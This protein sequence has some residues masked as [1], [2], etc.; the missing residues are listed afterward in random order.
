MKSAITRRDFL[1]RAALAGAS[2]ALPAHA[3]PARNAMFVSLN[4]ALTA[5]KNVGW[6]E[7]ARLAARVGYGGVDW[8]L[9]AARTEGLE[10]TKALFAE[11]KIEPTITNLPMA[12]PLPFGGEEPLFREALVTLADQAAFSAA[13]GC[14]KMMVV[15]PPTGPTPKDEFRKAVRDRIAAVAEVLQKSDTRLGLEFLGVQQF[16]AGRGDGPPPHPFIWTLPET[17][18][19]AKDCGT[20][21]G[22][23]LDVWH[24][25][26]SGGTTADI[27]ATDKARIVHVHMSDAKPMAPEAVRDNMRVMPGE[28]SIDLVGFF[29]ALKAIGYADG[30]S[31][32]PLGRIPAE[33]SA[34]DAARLGL[35]TTLAVMRKAGVA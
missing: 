23:I 33:M 30:V 19:L 10:R 14:R 26:H 21:I 6:P 8:S 7:F 29:Q 35:Q 1:Q 28:G 32:E 22:A 11:L 31:P 25:H 13:I 2:L 12:R 3:Q 16:R 5:G 9:D 4:G 34:E 24:W 27:K 20:N 18:A 15:L 17:V